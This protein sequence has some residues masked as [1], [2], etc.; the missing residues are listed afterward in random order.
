MQILTNVL[1]TVADSENVT[2]KNDQNDKIYLSYIKSKLSHLTYL[3][4][5]NT[6]Y[7]SY[8]IPN[9]LSGVSIP[10][11]LILCREFSTGLT[12]VV[13]RRK[14][15]RSSHIANRLYSSRVRSNNHCLLFFSDQNILQ[16]PKSSVSSCGKCKFVNNC[17][18][19]FPSED[20]FVLC[21]ICP[22]RNL[23]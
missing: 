16:T 3:E 11:T 8:S 12:L 7:N 9:K 19:H 14:N 23:I 10:P 1:K 15:Y 2:N 6:Q 18:S 22:S 21:P 4:I 20:I 17:L 5:A 13:F